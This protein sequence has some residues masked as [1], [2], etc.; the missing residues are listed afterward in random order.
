MYIYGY[1]YLSVCIESFIYQNERTSWIPNFC[2]NKTDWKTAH[3]ELLTLC[4]CLCVWVRAHATHTEVRR[5]PQG[6]VVN[7]YF[8]WN[9][10]FIL[11]YEVY[12]AN[13]WEMSL[14]S[15][16]PYKH[17]E[18]RYMLPHLVYMVPM[19]QTEVLML[20]WQLLMPTEPSSQPIHWFLCERTNGPERIKRERESPKPESEIRL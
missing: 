13:F 19:S 15:I 7:F 12:P 6:Q 11:L 20:A 3:L 9:S 4:V 16:L 17:Q 18:Y 1:I 2:G 8:V 5:K 14:P 10:L